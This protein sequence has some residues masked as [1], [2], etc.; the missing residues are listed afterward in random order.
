MQ[1]RLDSN[2]HR[3]TELE[4]IE[5]SL[6]VEAERDQRHFD[7][8]EKELKEGHADVMRRFLAAND[9]PQA[10]QRKLSL[11][12]DT[13]EHLRALCELGVGFV[14]DDLGEVRLL[15]VCEEG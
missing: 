2:Y 10:K 6:H 11:L 7:E 14:T 15:R 4:K 8:K 5:I 1:R 13:F 9:G 12:H 3:I